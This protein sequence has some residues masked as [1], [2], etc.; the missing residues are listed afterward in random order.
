MPSRPPGFPPL[1]INKCG[2]MHYKA[3]SLDDT[4]QIFWTPSNS[5]GLCPSVFAEGSPGVSGDTPH[6]E[7]AGEDID[8]LEP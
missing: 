3:G 5:S 1:A 2:R 7:K 8:S 6:P 4:A